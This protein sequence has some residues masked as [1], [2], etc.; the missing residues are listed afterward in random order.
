MYETPGIELIQDCKTRGVHGVVAEKQGKKIH[1]KAKKAVIMCTGGFENNQDMI[2]DYLLLPCGYPYGTPY[3][4]GDGI[5]M[6]QAAGADLWHMG[7]VAG[8]SLSFRAPGVDWAFGAGF[9]SPGGGYIFVANHA[10]RFIPRL[11]SAGELGSI[12]SYHYQG[13]GNIG[14]CLAFGRIA[15]ENAVS[16]TPWS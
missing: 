3:N 1:V 7:N 2:R 16:E 4:T 6:A 14:E 11:Y 10:T 15:A 5:R 13:A 8:P 12:F 9:S